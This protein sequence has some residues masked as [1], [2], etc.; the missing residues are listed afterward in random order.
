[1]TMQKKKVLKL[2]KGF[3][4]RA[5]NCIRIARNRVEKSLTHAY[6]DRRVKKRLFRRMWISRINAACR[7][8]SLT[9][10]QFM[11]GLK[12]ANIN[13][14]RKVLSELAANE[15]LSFRAIVEQVRTAVNLH[16]YKS[17]SDGHVA[18]VVT[19]NKYIGKQLRIKNIAKPITPSSLYLTRNKQVKSNTANP[20][21]NKIQLQ[22]QQSQPVTKSNQIPNKMSQTAT[23]LA[24]GIHYGCVVPP[25]TRTLSTTTRMP[26]RIGNILG[27]RMNSVQSYRVNSRINIR[28]TGSKIGLGFLLMSSILGSPKWS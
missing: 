16:P 6:R 26:S 10:S 8:Q 27:N 28:A 23:S 18:S 11:N 19:E 9:Y 12:K 22:I 3:Y 24:T 21:H 4:G 2:A 20:K 7:L 15:P 14:N 5:K 13:L 17:A 1:M 25:T